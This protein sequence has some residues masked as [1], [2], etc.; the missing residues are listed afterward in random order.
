M[1]EH[2]D[3]GSGNSPEDELRRLLE[4][5]LGSGG[6]INAD[7]L[8]GVAGLP[9]DPAALTNMLHQLQHSLTNPSDEFNWDTV[10]D[11]ARTAATPNQEVD[12]SLRDEYSRAFTL[13]ELWLTEVTG[14]TLNA[15]SV[16]PTTITRYEWLQQSLS[17]WA[18]LSEPVAQSVS[19]ALMDMLT[20][21]V[22][23]EFQF[24]VHQSGQMLRSVGRSMFAM[25][26][27]HVLG[28]L[29]NEVLSGGDIGMPVIAPGKAALVPQNLDAWA[30]ELDNERQEVLV[31]FAV[32]ELAYAQLFEHARWLRLHLVSSITEFARGITID[33]SR[34]EDIVRDM[35]V[36]SPEELKAVLQ[37]GRLIPPRTPEQQVALERLETSLALIEGWVEVVTEAATTR[38]PNASALAEMVRRR[39]AT[40][41]PA[42]HAFGSLVGL[43]IRPRRLREAANMWR[44]VHERVGAAERDRLWEHRDAVPTSEDIDDPFALVERLAANDD[45]KDELDSDLERLL[46]D[47]DSF[48]DAPAGGDLTPPDKS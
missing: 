1:T 14:D 25:Q 15:A 42:E 4:Q 24:A 30:T 44:L 33:A 23:D 19:D 5:M 48:G 41:S 40:G 9:A 7:Q 26:L 22:P 12:Q 27:G 8:A 37:S 17:G 36:N 46:G 35:D 34:V 20:E 32:R 45:G 6:S 43:E 29:A 21:N 13:A 31:Y 18:E 2:E 47:P 10:R 38:L 3:A 28:Q 39:R 11:A 16:V